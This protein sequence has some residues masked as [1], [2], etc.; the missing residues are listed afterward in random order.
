[1]VDA[2]EPDLEEVT[3]TVR[4]LALDL[5]VTRTDESDDEPEY[6]SQNVDHYGTNDQGNDYTRYIDGGY[7]Y[8]NAD[9]SNYRESADGAREYTAPDGDRGWHE[10]ADGNREYW[11][12]RGNDND[13]SDDEAG[14]Q[15]E[16]GNDDGEA[17][18]C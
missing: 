11:D 5:S 12:N 15:N 13:S 18:G 14:Y 3:D 9:G 10:D 7:G 1:M 2:Y 16:D 4:G 17:D 6:S 8:N